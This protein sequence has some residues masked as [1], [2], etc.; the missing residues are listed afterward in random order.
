MDGPYD[1]VPP[2]YWYDTEP[3]RGRRGAGFGF[4]SEL[5][6]GVGTPELGSLRRFLSE[7]DL[8]DLWKKPNKDL[9]HMSTN[10]S[11][12]YSRRIYNEG[13]FRRYGAPKSLDDYL[14][15]AQMMDYEAAR[16]QHEA[17]SSQ[18]NAARPATGTIY[19]MLNSAWP[20]LHWNQF[21]HYMHPAGSYFGSKTGSRVEHV[22]YD[23]VRQSAWVINHS[24]DRQGPRKIA[25]E[26]VDLGGAALSTQTLAVTTKANTAANMGKVSDLGRIKNVAFLRLVL[27]DDE[28]VALSRNVYWLT[29]AVDALDWQN[30]TWYH[31]PV[32]KFCDFAA[33]GDMETA[34]VSLRPASGEGGTALELQNQSAVPAFFVRLNL[35]DGQ[36]E[37]VN[38]VLWSDNYVTLWPHE[39]LRLE[40]SSSGGGKRVQVSGGNVRAFEVA[41]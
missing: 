15:K 17:Y 34:T 28:G 5:G 21:D 13:L 14:L 8:E 25:V 16:A 23:Y 37:D 12:F 40:V 22:A 41:L 27:S 19:W 9:F 33:L 26:L 24:L 6:A 7:G 35:V 39:T 3:S 36:G 11:S 31:T 2:N 38:P 18:W 29:A 10:A 20:S 32:T 30:S 1:W 4:G